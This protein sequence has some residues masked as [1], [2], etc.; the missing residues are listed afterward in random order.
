MSEMKT[1]RTCGIEKEIGAFAWQRARGRYRAT[2]RAC[3]NSQN[4][5]YYRR[6]AGRPRRRTEEQKRQQWEAEYQRIERRARYADRLE[7]VPESDPWLDLAV[8][9]VCWQQCVRE[10]ESA[11]RRMLKQIVTA[12]WSIGG[13]ADRMHAAAMDYLMETGDLAMVRA[14][15]DDLVSLARSA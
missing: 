8:V 13:R 12:S 2:C 5:D 10:G 6:R 15:L 11:I 1:C 14:R 9:D 3:R 4:R 7:P